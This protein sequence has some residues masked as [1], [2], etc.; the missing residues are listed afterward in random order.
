MANV[1][2][3]LY[4]SDTTDKAIKNALKSTESDVEGVYVFDNVP[5]GSYEVIAIYSDN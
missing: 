2:I 5:L 3:Y 4:K 1:N